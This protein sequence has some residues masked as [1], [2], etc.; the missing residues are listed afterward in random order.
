MEP[1]CTPHLGAHI[2]P[3]WVPYRLLTGVHLPIMLA[4]A[5]GSIERERAVLLRNPIYF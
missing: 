5:P 3:I 2:G 1:G 4:R